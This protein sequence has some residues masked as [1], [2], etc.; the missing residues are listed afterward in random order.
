MVNLSRLFLIQIIIR[1]N[2]LCVKDSV[3]IDRDRVMQRDNN[4]HKDN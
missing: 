4:S 1:L 2:D 3:V